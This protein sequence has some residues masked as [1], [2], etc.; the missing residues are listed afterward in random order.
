MDGPEFA[1][2]PASIGLLCHGVLNEPASFTLAMLA[3]IGRA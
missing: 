2:V 1:D 3:P